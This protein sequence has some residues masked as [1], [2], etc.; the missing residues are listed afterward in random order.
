MY[1]HVNMN[2][3]M[4]ISLNMNMNIYKYLIIHY[5]CMPSHLE[6]F[7]NPISLQDSYLD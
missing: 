3:S 2:M 4:N 5:S 7:I 1:V 6:H